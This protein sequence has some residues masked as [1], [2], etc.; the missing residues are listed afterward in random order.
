[1]TT[2]SSI[3]IVEAERLDGGV[4]IT[5]EDGK[6][7]RYSASLLHAMF[8]QAEEVIWSEEEGE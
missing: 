1:M 3:R 8:S 7:A 5:F 6:C 2:E 4:L